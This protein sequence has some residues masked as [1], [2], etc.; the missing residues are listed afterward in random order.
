[1]NLFSLFSYLAL[2]NFFCFYLCGLFQSHITCYILINLIWFVLNYH[3]LN[4]IIFILKKIKTNHNVT[5]NRC[6]HTISKLLSNSNKK[7]F[8]KNLK[9]SQFSYYEDRFREEASFWLHNKIIS[10]DHV[11][12]PYSDCIWMIL[13]EELKIIC[14]CIVLSMYVSHISLLVLFLEI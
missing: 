1:M 7:L 2:Y 8:P 10:K 6:R 13:T 9:T 4:I 12:V 3:Y 11:Y 5:I 14:S